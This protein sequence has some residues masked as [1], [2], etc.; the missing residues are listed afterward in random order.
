LKWGSIVP[1][2]LWIAHN[3]LGL[4]AANS[5]KTSSNNEKVK[6]A[7][8]ADVSWI[9][10]LLKNPQLLDRLA[11]LAPYVFGIGMVLLLATAV[12][13]VAGLLFDPVRTSTLWHPMPGVTRGNEWPVLCDLYWRIQWAGSPLQLLAAG[14]I[15]AF[16]SLL[17]S[18]RVDV[19]DFSLHHFYR[20]RLVRCY[21]GASNPDRKPQPFTGFDPND[22]VAL[23]DFAA[24]YPGPYPIL[25]AALNITSGAELGYG[26]R[27]AKSFV[28]TPLYCGYDLIF[29][30]AGPDRFRLENACERSYSRTEFGRT[31]KSHTRVT[32][33]RG[34][35]LG[36]A[37]GISGAAASPNMGY[38]TSPATALFMT[39]FD[40]RLGWWMGN[41]R[42][43]PNWKSPGP[44]SG[45][46]YLLSELVAQSDQNKGYVYL[47]DGGHFENLAVYELIKRHCKVIVACDADCDSHYDF[48]NLVA[49]IEKARSDF[50]A[51]ISI[52]FSEIRP[53]LDV[54]ESKCNFAVGDIFFD[55][56]NPDD[57]GK[58]FYLKASLPPRQD[59]NTVNQD[60]LPD[61]V[62]RYSEEHKTF[63][64]QSTADQWFDELQ[65]ESYRAL[66]QYIGRAAAGEIGPEIERVLG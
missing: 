20:N 23:K 40:V 18:R 45:L 55:P 25:N 31:A 9:A 17:L 34:I 19:N 24:N 15:L 3:Y 22:D 57:R 36:T 11:R 27:R 50:G 32:S 33:G 59:E 47:S 28:F 53:P 21:L 62:W 52:D 60:S 6:P 38:Y 46:G 54:R 48:E 37:A 39:L 16:A 2:V 58:L 44:T 7:N 42:F 35:A 61:D 4:K 14:G 5:P 51:R 63:P 29:P 49:L 64:H 10:R 26:T 30:G 13:I 65:F 43:T 12:H 66:G 41:P 1:A 8:G 56:Q